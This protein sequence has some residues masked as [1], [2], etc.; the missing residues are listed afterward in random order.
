LEGAPLTVVDAGFAAMDPTAVTIKSTANT[1]G[2]IFI[3]GLI[4]SRPCPD[5]NRHMMDNQCLQT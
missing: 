1:A 3:V 4:L 5:E 2:R